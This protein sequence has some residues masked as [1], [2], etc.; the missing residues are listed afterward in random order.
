MRQRVALAMA[1]MC[2][3]QLLLA[4]EPT[5]ALDVSVQAKIL[6]LL[7]RV[8]AR[9][10]GI[11]I[12]THDLGVV[13][14]IA[15]RVAVMYA[16]RLVECAPVLAAVRCTGASVH[17]RAAGR[18]AA[19]ARAAVGSRSRASQGNHRGPARSRWDAHSRRA[20]RRQM[21]TA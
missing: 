19:I 18:R 5:T 15:D 3:P 20:A 1:L 7:R 9:G 17:A 2:R 10:I 21:R 6:E 14:A 11:L 8:R 4:D 16:G 12:I 13:A